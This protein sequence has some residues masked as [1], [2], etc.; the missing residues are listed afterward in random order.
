MNLTEEQRSVPHGGAPRRFLVS[1]SFSTAFRRLLCELATRRHRLAR[2][3]K[4]PPGRL[5]CGLIGAGRFF[6]YAYVPALNRSSSSLRIVGILARNERT[7]REAQRALRYQTRAFASLERLL[8]SGI[9][10]V[11]ILAP[12]HLHAAY[13]RHALER[14]LNVFCEKPLANNIAEAL[15]LKS[16]AEK[17][18][19]IVM[20]DF[21]QR[22][23]D[24]NRDK[25][26]FAPARFSEGV[27]PAPW[28]LAPA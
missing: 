27:A 11:L 7:I 1:H 12:N 5:G 17:Q 18:G 25:Q 9:N 20:V 28:P 19:R 23:L 14:G 6:H 13:A 24:R 3:C 26:P 21:N 22:Y 8:D 15:S 4:P 2:R 10:S 16:L